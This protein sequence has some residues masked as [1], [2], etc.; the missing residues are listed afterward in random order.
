MNNDLAQ[1]ADILVDW[2][3]YDID[4]ILRDCDPDSGPTVAAG[5]FLKCLL[6][7]LSQDTTAR[8]LFNGLLLEELAEVRARFE[9]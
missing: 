4:A 7:T 1:L 2:T 8:K 9:E 3:R 6:F 5:E